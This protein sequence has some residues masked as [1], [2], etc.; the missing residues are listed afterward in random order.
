MQNKIGKKKHK[1]SLSYLL[2]IVNIVCWVY[3][4]TTE[5]NNNASNDANDLNATSSNVR[6]KNVSNPKV[7]S[8]IEKPEYK[9]SFLNEK[10]HTQYTRFGTK[11]DGIIIAS[12]EENEPSA[13]ML[14]VAYIH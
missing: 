4:K 10:L 7:S 13:Y 9:N 14:R 11:K 2:E 12:R 6:L 5:Y 3:Q 8:T 1:K